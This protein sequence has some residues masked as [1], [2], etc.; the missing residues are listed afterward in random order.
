M[1]ENIVIGNRK[2]LIQMEDRVI[3]PSAIARQFE[4]RAKEHFGPF[5]V[6]PPLLEG[7]GLERRAEIAAVPDGPV[8]NDA[9]IIAVMPDELVKPL[10]PD[11][12][13]TVRLEIG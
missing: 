8:H 13:I 5:L 9:A 3:N 2:Q 1:L 10:L 7:F 12:N 4:F 6:S 11:S